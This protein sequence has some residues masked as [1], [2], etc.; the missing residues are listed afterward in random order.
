[1]K[2]HR[3]ALSKLIGTFLL[4]V[5]MIAT[6]VSPVFAAGTTDGSDTSQRSLPAGLVM[7]TDYPGVQVKAGDSVSFTL[8]FSNGGSGQTVS[9][10]ASGLP[11]G[12]NGYFQGGTSTITSVY[13]QNGFNDELATYTVDVPDDVTQGTY[14]VTLQAAGATETSTLQLSMT[15]SDANYGSSKITTDYSSKSGTAGS[16]LTYT[17]TIENNSTVDQTYSLSADAPEGW[18]VSFAPSDSSDSSSI[19]SIDVEASSDASVT[20]SVTPPENAQ[21]GDYEI[22]I[23]VNS[24][25]EQLST[26]LKATISGNYGLQISTQNETLSFDVRANS[27][28]SVVISVA[29]TGNTD[30]SNI[31]LSAS[32]PTD[33]TVEFSSDTIDSLAAGETKTVTAKVTP[34][35]SAISGDYS[36]TITATTDDNSTDAQFRVTVKTSTGWGVICVIIIAAIAGILYAIFKKFGRH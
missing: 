26:T 18:D 28:S 19:S 17:A 7:S 21:A 25:N 9:L 4:L 33:W 24:E 36:M 31:S 15:V 8:N 10:S 29:N 13:V 3:K 22:P 2:N 23:S 20:V 5:C 6:A 35:E 12:V 11:D 1:M 16:A 32:A 30:L 34:S 27:E 14:T